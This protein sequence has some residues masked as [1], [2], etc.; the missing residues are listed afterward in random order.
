M[1]GRAAFTVLG[2]IL[3]SFTSLCYGDLQVG[4]YKKKCGF[5]EV[6]LMVRK[7]ITAQFYNDSTIVAALLRL[8]FHDCFVRGC[9]ASILLDGNSTE[10][11]APPNFSVRGFDLIDQAKALVEGACPG[12]VSCADIIAIAA[13]DAVYLAGGGWYN[14]ETGRRDGL[15]S[16]ASEVDLPA[17]S[18]SVS[19]AIAAFGR[20]GLNTTDMVLLLGGHTVG[21]THCSL[22]QD[23][24]YNFQN[25]GKPDPTMDTFLASILRSKCPQNAAKDNTVNLDQNPESTDVVDKSY[26]KQL[27]IK[28]GILQIDQELAL[29][30]QTNATVMSL[31]TGY[32]F[33]AQ[34]G[35]AMVKMGAIEV[36]TGTQ[37]PK[38]DLE[39]G[40]AWP[41]PAANGEPEIEIGWSRNRSSFTATASLKDLKLKLHHLGHPLIK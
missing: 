38:V 36:L 1:K 31:A 41:P 11:N 9:D 13:R 40:Q 10:K 8:H 2:F 3:L 30:P 5:K 12:L 25:T 24:L 7:V 35:Q 27:M 32:K 20:K 37:E 19:Q 6:E 26:Y 34:F 22:L 15:V 39:S 18:F 33:S 16:L 28:R 23:R 14:V 29:D 4:F 21:V 17:P